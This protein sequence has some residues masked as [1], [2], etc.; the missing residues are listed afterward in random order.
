MRTRRQT[1]QENISQE[2]KDEIFSEKKNDLIDNVRNFLAR[3]DSDTLATRENFMSKVQAIYELFV[4]LNENKEFLFERPN[5]F[6]KF[7][8]LI[9]S[10]SE[11]M[12]RQI[13]EYYEKFNKTLRFSPDEKRFCREVLSFLE[14]FDKNFPSIV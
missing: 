6:G 9:P 3:I 5:V 12:K 10:K 13:R 14:E 8:A 4:F 7:L 11:Q 2:K 1:N